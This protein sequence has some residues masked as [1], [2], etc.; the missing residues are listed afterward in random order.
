MDRMRLL[1][2]GALAVAF[3]LGAT[4]AG[5]VGAIAAYVPN[6]DRI[7]DPPYQATRLYARDGQLVASFYRENREFT[8]L[9]DVPGVMRHAVLAIEDDR[10]YQHGGV[11]FR[12]I[13][14]ASLRNL[15]AR[16]LVEGG[17]TITQQLARS[18]FLTPERSFNRKATEAVLALE[19]ERR[20]T[21][22]EILERYLNQV[23]FGQGAY[24][25]GMA[26]RVFFGKSPR[27]LTLDESALLA[28]LIRA[29]S[30]DN[31][32]GH[33]DRALERRAVVLRRM[34]QL[35]Y[36]TSRDAAG[37]QRAP[38]RLSR[39]QPAGYVGMRAPYFAS[40]VLQYLIGRYGEET[41]YNGGL[42]V[43]TTLDLGMQEAA[44][45]SVRQGIA[46]AEPLHVSQG[47]L[48]ALDPETGAIRAMVGGVD[49]AE[50]KFNRAWQA[51]RQAGSSFKPF[52]YTAAVA[53]GWRPWKRIL[54]APVSYPAGDGTSWRPKNYDRRYRGWVT[55]RRA[56]ER[57]INVPAVRTLEEI[58]PD[59]V[60]SYA[61]RMGIA[62]PLRSNLSLALGASE[63]TPLEMAS[64]YGTLATLG[65]RAQPMA[66]TLVTDR[67]GRVLERN[68][69][70][71]EQ[72]LS[73]TVAYAMVDML[74]GVISHGTGRAASLDRP[75]AGKTGTSDDYRNAW[76]IGFTPHLAT[77]VWVGN[78]DNTPMQRVTGGTV[79][80]QVWA[81]FM[82][83]AVESAPADDWTPP[84]GMYSLRPPVAQALPRR[85]RP[86]WWQFLASILENSQR[87]DRPRRER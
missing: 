22:D 19:L 80:A 77:A 85:D 29:P 45:R 54:D 23:Y 26:A 66:V 8:P 4:A 61:R 27:E 63:V 34:A 65:I 50:S 47:A 72:A 56:L 67:A 70:R 3:I 86:P 58:G 14:R 32:Y 40:M 46:D 25:V 69:P 68:T 55:M 59:T 87:R 41:V 49:F 71:R 18:L 17:S 12:A 21:K 38:L 62:S 24:G 11:D 20:L 30:L 79:P 84:P 52:I 13:A 78:D 36:V 31:P 73:E 42:R 1:T 6:R 15:R 2:V 74:K 64:A 60:I 44:Q 75:V 81:A 28:G 5:V 33:P 51:E 53:A 83:Q 9:G 16:A 57:S 76:F 43:Y 82:R 10:F 7:Y 39:D 48:V 35:G 37:A